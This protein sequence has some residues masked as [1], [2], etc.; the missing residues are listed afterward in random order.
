[1]HCHPDLVMDSAALGWAAEV[2]QMIF[3]AP[4]WDGGDRISLFMFCDYQNE[5][6]RRRWI[7]MAIVLSILGII[8]F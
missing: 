8:G 1:M 5:G 6:N 2:R 4:T 3:I 7:G